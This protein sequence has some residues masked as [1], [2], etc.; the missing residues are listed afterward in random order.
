MGY[1]GGGVQARLSDTGGTRLTGIRLRA[2][3]DQLRDP[4]QSLNRVG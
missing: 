1:T 3:L 4:S 2:A